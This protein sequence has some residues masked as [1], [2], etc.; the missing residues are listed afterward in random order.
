MESEELCLVSS[1]EE[2]GIFGCIR[3]E[4]FDDAQVSDK[5]MGKNTN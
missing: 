5:I 2:K 1:A 3:Y 4:V